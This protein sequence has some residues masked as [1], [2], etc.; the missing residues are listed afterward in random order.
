MKQCKMNVKMLVKAP[1][2]SLQVATCTVWQKKLKLEI[3]LGIPMED[4]RCYTS[5][6]Q[7]DCKRPIQCLASSKILTPTPL[8]ARHWCGGRTH[9]LG[10]V[11]GEGVGG[12]KS[13]VWRRQTLLCTL[14]MQVR[15]DL[16]KC[17]KEIRTATFV[18]TL[19]YSLLN[20]LAS[21]PA[22]AY[23]SKKGMRWT[24]VCPS[25]AVI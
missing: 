7:R 1:R 6:P 24:F 21:R 16:R 4:Q 5:S 23:Y 17:L 20:I 12:Q 13:I 22:D 19:K 15:C 8:T 14:P 9:S 3:E 25:F 18:N 2:L 11:G 10:A